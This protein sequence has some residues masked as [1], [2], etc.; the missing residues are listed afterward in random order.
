MLHVYLTSDEGNGFALHAD[1]FDRLRCPDDVN[2]RL[3][4]SSQPMALFG[5]EARRGNEAMVP[6]VGGH[7]PGGRTCERIFEAVR[8]S[9]EASCKSLALGRRSLQA[10]VVREGEV[11]A[12]LES[13]VGFGVGVPHSLQ[14]FVILY[15]DHE[16]GSP[17]AHGL[18]REAGEE[19]VGSD[20][21]DA[22]DFSRVIG[23]EK[24]RGELGH[25]DLPV[26]NF[27]GDDAR[28]DF[29]G[30]D[31]RFPF[32][33][34]GTGVDERAHCGEGRVAREGKFFLRG[35]V[36]GC[37]VGLERTPDEGSFGEV[38]LS[39]EGLHL[40]R[41]EGVCVQNDGAGV[42]TE[43][44]GGEG[45][46]PEEGKVHVDRILRFVGERQSSRKLAFP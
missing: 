17:R 40:R 3:P 22:C 12:C 27:D 37:E 30:Q 13:E 19:V 25:D 6:E 20:P 15:G 11:S 10:E 31:G 7:A 42:A 33:V 16:N 32:Q 5:D 45:V 29:E 2:F 43:L 1:C 38:H 35:E 18:D 14:C 46:D 28:R 24:L 44:S 34:D 4:W 39:G 9:S 21:E 36:A 41:S 26:R 23:P 8:R